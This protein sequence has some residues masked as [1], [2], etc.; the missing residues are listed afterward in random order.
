MKQSM[1]FGP[2]LMHVN[3]VAGF[4]AHSAIAFHSALQLPA[5][6]VAQVGPHVVSS[7]LGHT[8]A[9]FAQRAMHEALDGPPVPLDMLPL[10]PVVPVPLLPV[11]PPPP[12]PPPA[13][14]PLLLP[15]SPLHEHTATER[16]TNDPSKSFFMG[17]TSRRRRGSDTLR[18]AFAFGSDR[19]P[20]RGK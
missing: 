19:H 20:S 8:A 2:S 11:P 18:L 3:V 10:P 5:S 1:V 17:D 12:P 4:R 15:S 6:F 16:K 7:S 14:P 13:V 9:S